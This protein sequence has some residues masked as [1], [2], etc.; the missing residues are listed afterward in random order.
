MGGAIWL[1]AGMWL[2]GDDPFAGLGDPSSSTQPNLQQTSVTQ[3]GVPKR[4]QLR[5]V[6]VEARNEMGKRFR[7]VS[8]VF[9]MDGIQIA[10]LTAP[11]NQPLDIASK[12][13][14]VTM[15]GGQHALTVILTYRGQS[16]GLF[17]YLD[18]YRFRSV[19]TYQFYLEPSEGQPIIKVLAR[20]RPGMFV[21]LENKPMLD[22]SA[23]FGFGVTPMSGVNHG[24]EV[25]V[26][27]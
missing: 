26:S 1:L 2:L 23:P 19:A 8:A 25:S 21:S 3:P 12:A 10:N 20:E 18:N 22:I 5:P 16:V 4:T 24:T 6:R 13:L 17:S 14:E 11:A 9:V 7:L 15:N 27:R